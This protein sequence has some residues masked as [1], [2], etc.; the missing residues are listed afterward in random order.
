MWYLKTL[1]FAINL[2]KVVKVACGCIYGNIF[3]HSTVW[4]VTVII[5]HY[6]G[7]FHVFE[8]QIGMNEFDHW[9]FLLLLKEQ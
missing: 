7:I 8:L 2:S 3:C 9:G 4:K 5:N 1:Q 6:T